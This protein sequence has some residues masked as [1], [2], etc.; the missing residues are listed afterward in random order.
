MVFSSNIFLF[1]FLP[2]F[3]LVYFVSPTKWKNFIILSF[4]LLFYFW[5]ES[6]RLLI[7][8]SSIVL[9]FYAAKSV[10]KIRSAKLS[11]FDL[12]PEAL[13]KVVIALTIAINLAILSY[14]KYANFFVAEILNAANLFSNSIAHIALPLGISFFTFQAMSYVIDVYREDVPPSKSFIDFACYIMSFPQLVAGPIVR[15]KDVSKQLIHRVIT[16]ES[17]SSGIERFILGLSKKILIANTVAKSADAI[18]ALPPDQLTTPLAWL[19]AI[20]YTLQIF[21][22]FSGYSDMAIGLGRMMGFEFCENFNF[23]YISKS[24]QEFWRRWHMS[25]SCWFKDYLYIPLGGNRVPRWR[26]YANLW[27]V[28]LLCGLWHGASWTFILW[29]AYHGAFLVFERTKMGTMLANLPRALQHSYT[30]LTVIVGWVLFRSDTV[31]QFSTHIQ[32]MFSIQLETTSVYSP[33]Y[34][35]QNDVLLALAFGIIFSMP[36]AL[37]K[38]SS[39]NSASPYILGTRYLAFLSLLVLCFL[40]LASASYN[41][42]L[43]FR[44]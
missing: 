2:L 22:D 40:S 1:L 11:I 41:P 17:F 20:L 3:L 16:V 44:F 39:S 8:V 14:Y 30:M 9:N 7:P 31:S 25:L 6:W 35:L 15:Y 26:T 18:F 32:K 36:T 13:N 27:I 37:L 43:Y 28:F 5:G 23:P 29:G 12:S 4:S 33:S 10:F 19:G 38:V 21:F 42:F 24:I 34:Y